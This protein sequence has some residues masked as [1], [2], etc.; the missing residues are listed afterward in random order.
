MPLRVT[1]DVW[2]MFANESFEESILF[3]NLSY[4]YRIFYPR[5]GISFPA[6]RT[7]VP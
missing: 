5:F 7:N 4:R 3:S 1:T 6:S 2:G